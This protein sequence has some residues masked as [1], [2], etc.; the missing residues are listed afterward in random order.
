MERSIAFKAALGTLCAALCAMALACADA[1]AYFTATDAVAYSFEV[2]E[3]AP[4]EPEAFAVYSAD[5]KSL[6]FYKRAS[7]PAAGDTFE[8]KT[9]TNVYRGIEYLYVP[10]EQSGVRAPWEKMLGYVTNVDIVDAISPDSCRSWFWQATNLNSV[11]GAEKL[12]LSRCLSL[13]RMFSTCWAL[14]S[15]DVST[16]D[17]SSVRSMDCMFQNCGALASLDV[18]SWNVGSVRDLGGVFSGCK[19]LP[20]IDVSSWDTASATDMA[21]LFSD[22]QGVQALDVS[23][24]DTSLV[25]DMS[26]MFYNCA[27]VTELDCSTW[28]T[29]AVTNMNA[30]FQKCAAL[31][32]IDASSWDTKAVRNTSYMFYD[33]SKLVTIYGGDGWDTSTCAQQDTFKGCKALVGGNG[34]RFS[35]SRYV[36]VYARLD[37][38]GQPG[39]LTLKA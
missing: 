39:Y 2:G 15:L 21:S 30:M 38:P 23:K 1:L 33:T 24:F 14:A 18:S 20:R 27:M 31:T 4:A 16:W 12:D 6:S 25:T 13:S 22:C 17:T 5:D 28:N 32:V 19:A 9:A 35:E 36:G 10:E 8:G 11:T 29:S 3:V 37:L 34:T 26:R 7:V